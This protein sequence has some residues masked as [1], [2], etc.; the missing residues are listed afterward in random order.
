MIESDD[1]RALAA[2]LDQVARARGISCGAY[3]ESCVRRRLSVRMRACGVQTFSEYADRLAADAEEYDRLLDTLTVNVTTFYRNRD[4]WDR[5]AEEI[6]PALW[7]RRGPRLRCWSAGC[8][9]G[10]EPYTLA[11]L[12]LRLAGPGG[13]RALGGPMIEASD[14]DRVSLE[15][16]RVGRYPERALEEMPADLVGSYLR[17][18]PEHADHWTVADSVKALVEFGAHDLLNA[19]PPG[20]YDLILLRNVV[21][22]FDRKVQEHLFSRMADALHTG[23]VLV[24]GKVE[25]L[26]GPARDQLALEHVRERIYRKS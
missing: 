25:S 16:A 6:L 14:F 10:E 9:S 15:R 20:T 22:Y 24:L 2:L 1:G 26:H 11:M 23:G 18:D 21:I 19:T 13:S 5:L 4:V 12:L 3:K 17:R 7:E 8:A